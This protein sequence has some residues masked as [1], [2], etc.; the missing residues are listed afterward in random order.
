MGHLLVADTPGGAAVPLPVRG[1]APEGVSPGSGIPLAQGVRA[2]GFSAQNSDLLPASAG[3]EAVHSPL[4][5]PVVA[6]I[7]PARYDH[8]KH[9]HPSS[10]PGQS[11]RLSRGKLFD[12]GLVRGDVGGLIGGVDHHAGTRAA[13]L[14]YVPHLRV[15][16]RH[17][18][19]VPALGEPGG[20]HGG[21]G[22][23]LGVRLPPPGAEDDVGAVD[24]L[25]VEPVVGLEGLPGELVVLGVAAAHQNAQ[26]AR[27]GE[28]T[29]P[30]GAPPGLLPGGC[31]PFHIA[32]VPQLPA[33]VGKILLRL[34]PAELVQHALQ[35]VPLPAGEVHLG[36][37]TGLR[38]L[39]LGVALEVLGRVLL[40]SQQ[41]VQGNVHLPALR[42]VIV[43]RPEDPLP[44]LHA[45]EIGGDELPEYPQP[46][47]VLGLGVLLLL[48]SQLPTGP[49]PGAGGGPLEI[50]PPLTDSLGLF[51]GFI[52]GVQHRGE[53]LPRLPL[54][55]AAVLLDGHIGEVRGLPLLTEQAGVEVPGTDRRLPGEEG[56][57]QGG[58]TA[59][60]AQRPVPAGAAGDLPADQGGET[61]KGVQQKAAGQSIRI[62]PA[63]E[64]VKTLPVHSQGIRLALGGGETV[65]EAGQHLPGL[66]HL[67]VHPAQAVDDPVL[68]VQ[69][70]QVGSAA[71][72]LQHQL[73][74]AWL[75]QLVHHLDC[76][77]HHPLQGGLVH[78]GQAAAPQVLAQ[79]HAEHRRRGG[80]LP[81]EGGQMDAGLAG[82]GAQEQ[83][84]AAPEYE[85]ELISDGLLHLFNAEAQKG[86]PHLSHNAGEAD[87]VKWHV[88]PPPS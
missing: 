78:G 73:P 11:R 50:R 88:D 32:G 19:A 54:H 24:P 84:P 64:P 57:G 39:G 3:Q 46:V 27:G 63:Q 71:H 69:E 80:V 37:Q 79:E 4:Q 81:R 58:G 33:D 68:A 12:K 52:E 72:A 22:H 56:V 67:H 13:G 21:L 1:I 38:S 83:P 60:S 41:G 49:V 87:G 31:R 6:E 55:G 14:L 66:A 75:P 77:N 51:P 59:G 25:G 85:N 65:K 35:P 36:G 17:P 26:P 7:P 8:A 23:G 18:A 30:A 45:V 61:E 9:P 76:Q 2:S 10:P 43:L 28:H 15:I 29:G 5:Q 86:P 40:G 53:G 70:D 48:E 34:R 47:P 42:V 62:G 16:D 82:P 44:P 74:S 20:Q